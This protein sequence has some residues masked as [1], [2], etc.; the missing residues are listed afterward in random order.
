MCA[1][2]SCLASS[3]TDPAG[4]PAALRRLAAG[5]DVETSASA[6]PLLDAP[7]YD[8]TGP[9]AEDNCE[10]RQAGEHKREDHPIAAQIWIAGINFL[11]DG[12]NGD[13]GCGEECE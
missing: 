13:R 1:E 4:G 9:G 11:I 3:A 5:V 7:P 6:H 8:A 2:V 12:V 10:K